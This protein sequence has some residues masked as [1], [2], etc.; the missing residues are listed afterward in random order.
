MKALPVIL[1]DPTAA[2]PNTSVPVHI[3]DS[4][5]PVL[6]ATI[7]QPTPYVGITTTNT[8]AL[9]SIAIQCVALNTNTVQV[10]R[11]PTTFK[12]AAANTA[13][14]TAIWTPAGGKK[15]RLLGGVI[16]S[17][18]AALA[19]AALTTLTL[20]D[21]AAAITLAFDIWIP[22]APVNTTPCIAFTLGPNGY[23]S[24]TADNVLNATLTA[25]L[26]SGQIR[27]TV[28]GTEE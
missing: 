20:L 4:V 19:A 14:A 7:A 26:L 2:S 15:F 3:A 27:V 16:T 6:Q 17:A 25:N 1:I 9:T 13:A 11:T 21:G 28:W 5:N 22:V 18:S 10:V 23:L 24:S 12:S 8:A